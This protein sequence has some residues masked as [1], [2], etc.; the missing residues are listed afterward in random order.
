MICFITAALSADGYIAKNP[1][2]PAF[3]TSKEDKKRFIEI[4]K[5][6][7]VVVMG[8]NTY[9]TLGRP[10]KERVNIVY[11]MKNEEIPVGPD[12][13]VEK[14]DKP[15]RELIKELAE[16]GFKEVAICGG[17]QVYTMFMESGVVN[18]LYLTIEPIIFGSGMKLFNKDMHYQLT[19]KSSGQT[20]SGALLLEYQVDYGGNHGV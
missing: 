6:A 5:R 1:L 7:G 4:T 2:H 8:L 20:D 10:L 3:W 9:K 13:K 19:L 18:K 15:P 16:R 14:T 11:A 12:Q 17:Q